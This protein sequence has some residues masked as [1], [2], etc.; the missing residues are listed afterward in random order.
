MKAHVEIKI[1]LKPKN[2]ESLHDILR[3]FVGKTKGWRF[4]QKESEDYQLMHHGPAGFADCVSVKGLKRAGVAL[5]NTDDKRPNSFRVTNIVPKE[6]SSLTL[7]E[8]NA[9]G[10]AFADHFRGWLKNESLRGEVD[11]RGPQKTL[12]DIIPGKKTR[13]LFEAWLHTPTP[14]SQA[15][16]QVQDVA[17]AFC[18]QPLA[19]SKFERRVCLKFS[20]CL[21]PI[22][23][24]RI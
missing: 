1:R 18:F 17:R 8:Y 22:D 23:E 12:A 14:L 9:I 24:P 19:Q 6:C 16:R 2:G 21:K 15:G 5:A 11:V 13:Q 10:L 20:N 4:P 3:A 7:G